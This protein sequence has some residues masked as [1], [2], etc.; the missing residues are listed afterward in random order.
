MTLKLY[1]IQR[2]LLAA[3]GVEKQHTVRYVKIELSADQWPVVTIER[4][5]V[6]GDEFTTA[7]EEFE[8][9]PRE[10]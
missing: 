4:D 6:V 1:E 3:L 7:I 10:M 8:L 2:R 5:L 9:R